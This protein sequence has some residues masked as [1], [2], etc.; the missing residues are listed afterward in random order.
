MVFPADHQVGKETV[1]GLEAVHVDGV[2]TLREELAVELLHEG[3]SVVEESLRVKRVR[4]EVQGQH[5][6]VQAHVQPE[7]SLFLE[8]D[9]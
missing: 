6:L 3:D 1:V 8:N 2:A 5:A 4:V 7:S 9:L